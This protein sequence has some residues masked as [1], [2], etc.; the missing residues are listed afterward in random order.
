MFRRALKA[1][2]PNRL[3]KDMFPGF[4]CFCIAALGLVAGALA[5]HLHWK[6]LAVM[7]L[8]L[9]GSGILGGFCCILYGW[10]Q[11]LRGPRN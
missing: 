7:S 11:M 2:L 4:V 1:F 8:V 3:N 9:M 10:F 5:S 6:W